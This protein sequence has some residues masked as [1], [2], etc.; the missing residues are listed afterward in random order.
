M[1]PN[2]AAHTAPLEVHAATATD[3]ERAEFRAHMAAVAPAPIAKMT[4][5][6]IT[7]ARVAESVKRVR[8]PENL[9]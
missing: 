5:H 6:Q 3:A 4:Q 9:W 2:I 1:H 7:T 8:D